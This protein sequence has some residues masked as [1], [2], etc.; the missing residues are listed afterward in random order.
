MNARATHS[1]VGRSCH[2]SAGRGSFRTVDKGIEITGVEDTL[3]HSHLRRCRIVQHA[4]GVA[5][6]AAEC[7]ESVDSKQ[8]EESGAFHGSLRMPGGHR[9]HQLGEV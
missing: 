1:E 4:V 9:L 8:N 6:S 3:H 2:R 7:D 5:A